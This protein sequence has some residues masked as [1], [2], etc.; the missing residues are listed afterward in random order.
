MKSK[1]KQDQQ[2]AFSTSNE[3]SDNSDVGKEEDTKEKEQEGEIYEEHEEEEKD[4]AEER[5]ESKELRE[6]Q[7]DS[8]S[9]YSGKELEK[10]SISSGYART[11]VERIARAEAVKCSSLV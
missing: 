3:A 5:K 6:Q 7:D 9:N 4:R 1:A 10:G 8:S 2:T 11:R